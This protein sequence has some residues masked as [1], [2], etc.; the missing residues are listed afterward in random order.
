MHAGQGVSGMLHSRRSTDEL[1]LSRRVRKTASGRSPG[2]VSWEEDDSAGT[3]NRRNLGTDKG[4]C[5]GGA[6]ILGSCRDNREVGLTPRKENS[7]YSELSNSGKCCL[8]E[9][10]PQAP[11]KHSNWSVY[12]VT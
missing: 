8:M 11:R 4:L 9:K 7:C 2:S 5:W 12:E 3:E 10:R 1:R 6:P